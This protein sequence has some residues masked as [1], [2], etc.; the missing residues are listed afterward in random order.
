MCDLQCSIGGMG[1]SLRRVTC[2][3]PGSTLRYKSWHFLIINFKESQIKKMG[4]SYFPV[5]YKSKDK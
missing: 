2:R 4:K 1:D 5:S 3:T